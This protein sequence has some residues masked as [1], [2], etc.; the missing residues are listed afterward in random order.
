[1]TLTPA[2]QA[3]KDKE[4]RASAFLKASHLHSQSKEVL[5]V[6]N[7]A[8]TKYV[9]QWEAGR[10]CGFHAGFQA[11]LVSQEV[12][13]LVGFLKNLSAIVSDRESPARHAQA[14]AILRAY[15][16]LKGEGT[17]ESKV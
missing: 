17:D 6:K 12:Q 10:A 13:A 11:A 8:D 15:G 2:Q 9:P 16:V 7:H 3:Q 5:D 14:Y 1:V 4:T